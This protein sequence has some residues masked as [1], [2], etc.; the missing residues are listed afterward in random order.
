VRGTIAG[1][2]NTQAGELRD[3]AR[4]LRRDQTHAEYRL[5]SRLRSR[6][7]C[8]VKFRRQHA[9]QTEK[10]QRRT[11][12]LNRRGYRVLRFWDNEVIEDVDAV[13]QQIAEV[14]GDPHPSPLPGREREK[15]IG[16]RESR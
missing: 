9:S 3:R 4:R 8:G 10:D 6:Q 2:S 14:L 7:L 16:R 13:L 12:L 15:T 11:E 1:R 5:W